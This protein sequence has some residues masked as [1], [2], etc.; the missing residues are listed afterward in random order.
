MKALEQAR[1][2]LPAKPG[3]SASAG[4][5]STGQ[6]QAP[7]KAVGAAKT[8]AASA[9][10]EVDGD[11]PGSVA[12]PQSA[13]SKNKAAK[14]GGVPATA[15][16]KVGVIDVMSHTLIKSQVVVSSSST[17]TQVTIVTITL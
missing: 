12:V 8:A 3:K 6:H 17:T 13:A 4:Q 14:P 11:G 9:M 15:Q 2:N 5:V 16:K 10:A 7:G 1:P